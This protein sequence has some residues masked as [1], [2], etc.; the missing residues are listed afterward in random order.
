MNRIFAIYELKFV[1][2]IPCLLKLNNILK[3]SLALL[4]FPVKSNVCKTLY[5]DINLLYRSG[6]MRLQHKNKRNAC[7]AIN[8]KKQL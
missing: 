4:I 8:K 1:V 6:N 3:H 5:T 2:K 7:I